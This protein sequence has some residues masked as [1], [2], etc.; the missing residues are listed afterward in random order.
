MKQKKGFFKQGMGEFMEGAIA[1][2]FLITLLI[3]LISFTMLHTAGG[4]MEYAV[5]VIGREIVTCTS[6]ED[7]RRT[8]QEQAELILGDSR[9]MPRDAIRADVGYAPGSDTEWEKGNF[10]FVTITAELHNLMP[11]TSGTKEVSD[12]VMIEY[13]GGNR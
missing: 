4:A 11:V 2:L 10:V 12:L 5:S 1:M 7:A 6:L 8:A 3:L 13:T 9:T